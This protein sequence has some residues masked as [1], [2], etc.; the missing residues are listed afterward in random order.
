[1]GELDGWRHC[2]VCTTAVEPEVGRVECPE[3]GFVTF[4]HSMP[5]ASALVLGDDGRV[6]LSR[7]A[8]DPAAGKWDLPGGFLEE[9]E[10]PLDC[11]R[12]ELREEAGIGLAE[13]ELLGIWM[14]E[15]DYKGRRVA[16]LNVYY[17]ARVGEG[18]PE[19]ADDVAELRW[20]APAEIPT[21]ELA[22]EHI[23]DV[24]SAW[25]NEHA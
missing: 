10:H 12:R 2:P 18:T 9:G 22:F 7:R 21:D 3:C 17:R 20:F 11:V 25:R 6:L 5:T 24:L 16:T 15:Y 23:P 8:N 19:P 13:E 14:D 1:V 4:A